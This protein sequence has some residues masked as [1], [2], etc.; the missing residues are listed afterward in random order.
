MHIYKTTCLINGKIYIGQRTKKFRT[1][2]YLGSET[3]ISLAINK[4]GKENFTKELLRECSSQ[5]ELDRWEQIYIIKHKSFNKYIGYNILKGSSNEFGCGSPMLIPEVAKKCSDGN[6]RFMSSDKGKQQ[7]IKMSNAMKEK[8]KDPKYAKKKSELGKALVGDKNPNYGNK[9]SDEQKKDLSDKMKGRYNGDK[10]PN[11][12]N[13]WSDEQK[14]SLSKKLK[15]SGANKGKNN[16]M[17]GRVRITDGLNNKT[18]VK[19]EDIPSG[20]R[21]GM[22]RCK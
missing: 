18:I 20:W 7:K 9:W 10:N 3:L 19:G 17:Y 4:Y 21:L 5:K 1:D 15:E 22:T 11:H 14:K 16:A 2:G 13:N 12:G 6:K 8:H